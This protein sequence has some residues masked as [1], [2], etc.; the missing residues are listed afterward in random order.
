LSTRLR[1]IIFTLSDYHQIQ[2]HGGNSDSPGFPKVIIIRVENLFAHFMDEIKISVVM[3]VFNEEASLEKTVNSILTQEGVSIEF[4]IVDDG[5]TDDS[6]ITLKKIARADK[7]VQIITQQNQG[8]T[9]ALKNGCAHAKG[10]YIARQDAGD[11]SLPGR[12]KAQF[13]RLEA[14]HATVLS[15]TAVRFFS[16]EAE[17]LF[18]TSLTSDQAHSGLRPT[19]LENM[20]GPPH[21]G[22]VMFNRQAYVECGGYRQNFYVAQDL[23]LWTRLAE[24]G[25]HA[26]TTKVYYEASLRRNAVSTSLRAL[27]EVSRKHIFKCL[28]ERKT[29][30]SDQA[31]LEKFSHELCK[32]ATKNIP[33]NDAEY[34]Y[35]IGSLLV[36][37]QKQKGRHY[38]KEAAASRPLHLKTWIK[39]LL[40]YLP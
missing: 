30:G 36:D 22:S 31:Y 12:L 4:I 32:D 39:L 2:L 37:K 13:D 5:S 16:E 9:L 20:Q 35:F 33:Q 19:S 23:D 24:R 34:F 18:E 29:T 25:D 14:E 11:Y 7:R 1:T 3:P 15:S 17:P 10:K 27:Q 40:S 8:V 28:I 26:S 21:H 6:N 38:F